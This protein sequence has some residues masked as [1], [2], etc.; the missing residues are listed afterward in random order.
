MIINNLIEL[1]YIYK[2][3]SI[4]ELIFCDEFNDKIKKNVFS[5]KL[6]ILTF[7]KF[8]NQKIKKNVLPKKL[9]NLKFCFIMI[10]K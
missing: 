7:G 10:K 5:N 8:F 3:S 2:I 9:E 4:N 1:K 6:I